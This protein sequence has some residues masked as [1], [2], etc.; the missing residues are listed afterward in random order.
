[1]RTAESG[2]LFGFPVVVVVE[3]NCVVYRFINYVRVMINFIS[4]KLKAICNIF[5]D[6]LNFDV[7]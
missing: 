4:K 7:K 5:M 3:N 6:F 1:M 2:S